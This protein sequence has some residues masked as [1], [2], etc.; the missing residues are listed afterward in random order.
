[1]KLILMRIKIL[2]PIDPTTNNPSSSNSNLEMKLGFPDEDDDDYDAD[3]DVPSSFAYKNKIDVLCIGHQSWYKS[4][5]PYPYKNLN[6]NL[7]SF[8]S[9]TTRCITISSVIPLSA[10]VIFQ[11]ASED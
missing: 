5:C 7:P 1:M 4:L 3:S 6:D 10:I 9:L 8:E 11:L 2:L